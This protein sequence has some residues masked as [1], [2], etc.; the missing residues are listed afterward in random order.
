VDGEDERIR[1]ARLI[2]GRV[3]Q[4]SVHVEIICTA[5]ADGLLFSEVE[6]RYVGIEVREALELAPGFSLKEELSGAIRLAC[7]QGYLAGA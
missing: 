4:D 2:V 6:R 5:P 3:G 1:L 7:E